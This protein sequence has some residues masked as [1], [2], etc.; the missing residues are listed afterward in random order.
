[1]KPA[2]PIP[3]HIE[4]NATADILVLH[5]TRL[6]DRKSTAL[7]DICVDSVC[8]C[9]L[10][11]AHGA[12]VGTYVADSG[13]YRPASPSE[14]GS[15]FQESK[16]TLKIYTMP[17]AVA[18]QA[19]LASESSQRTLVRG[20]DALTW[21][22]QLRT[23]KMEK[24]NGLIGVDSEQ[25]GGYILLKSGDSVREESAILIRDGGV[26]PV[27]DPQGA[28][29]ASLYDLNPDRFATRCLR[30][31]QSARR[32]SRGVLES[33][34]NIAGERFQT[35]LVR[36]LQTQIRP[37]QWNINVAEQGIDDQHFFPGLDATAQAYRAV[38]LGI[39]AQMN[40]A[41]GSFIAQRI[42][43][44]IFNELGAEERAELEAHRLIPAAFSE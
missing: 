22:Q 21:N 9:L 28:W 26:S 35:V 12:L 10:L 41:M 13:D 14:M 20:A 11:F 43:T 42:L 4:A 34:R 36:E 1:M 27:F 39:G 7:I 6:R 5:Q 30:L 31:R 32:W 40:F 17:D 15:I 33:Y 38:F 44:E 29:E 3:A 23:W 25:A 24:V 8:R 37:W 16:V 18:R 2:I 19:W